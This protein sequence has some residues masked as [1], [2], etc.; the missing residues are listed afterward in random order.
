MRLKEMEIRRSSIER[1][2]IIGRFVWNAGVWLAFCTKH[3]EN[4]P[5]KCS[6][7]AIIQGVYTMKTKLKIY[8]NGITETGL[9]AKS[10]S[11]FLFQ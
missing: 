7:M 8:K 3:I 6:V 4:T 1:R 2:V 9:L 11:T 5:Y 10:V